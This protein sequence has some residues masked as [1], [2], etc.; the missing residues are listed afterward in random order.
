[1]E[2]LHW[3]RKFGV[4]GRDDHGRTALMYAA[5]W[6]N[7]E[8]IQFLVDNGAIVN[9]T[10]YVGSTTL[11]KQRGSTEARASLGLGGSALT[12]PKIWPRRGG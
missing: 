2:L 3:V 11:T 1:M 10:T 6:G 8:W 7:V 5:L 4:E 9:T 12:W